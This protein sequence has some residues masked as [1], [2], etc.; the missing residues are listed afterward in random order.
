MR[1]TMLHRRDDKPYLLVRTA[2]QS[3]ATNTR[4]IDKS[5]KIVRCASKISFYKKRSFYTRFKICSGYN[6]S[7]L[8]VCYTENIF[9]YFYK[10]QNSRGT[11]CD[12]YEH[13]FECKFT[14][15][16]L[17]ATPNTQ[18]SVVMSFMPCILLEENV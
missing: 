10:I 18:F 8:Y 9:F 5:L 17:N 16:A 6:T 15:I 11:M 7:K 13:N 4:R 3:L 12:L 2:I 14:H 1:S